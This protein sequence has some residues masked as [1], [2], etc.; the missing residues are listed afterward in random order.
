M[1]QREI[2]AGSKVLLELRRKGLLFLYMS[3]L[4]HSELGWI[5][6]DRMAVGF[7]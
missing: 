3:A 5:N 1:K 4:H 2:E 7:H 6:S